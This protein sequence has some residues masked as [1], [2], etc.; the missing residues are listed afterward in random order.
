M[1]RKERQ[2]M[3]PTRISGS[4]LSSHQPDHHCRF[5]PLSGVEAGSI[6]ALIQSGS[7]LNEIAEILKSSRQN[8]TLKTRAVS[9]MAN[10]PFVPVLWPRGAQYGWLAPWSV[11]SAT[12]QLRPCGQ[13][14]RSLLAPKK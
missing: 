1:G 10:N 5:S 12:R 13:S 3:D 7:F 2:W 14:V 6:L 9:K 8:F 11:A 4:Q